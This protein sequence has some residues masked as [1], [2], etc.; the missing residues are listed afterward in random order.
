MVHVVGPEFKSQDHSKNLV[1]TLVVFLTIYKF[2]LYLERN[3][4]DLGW[5]SY[6]TSPCII[7]HCMVS[8][9]L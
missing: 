6:S 8:V 1:N 7:L 9:A 5:R 4:G 3:W 2:V